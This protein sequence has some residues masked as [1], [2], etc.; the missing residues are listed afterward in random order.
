[1]A[2]AGGRGGGGFYFSCGIDKV[3]ALKWLK[4]ENPSHQHGGG[5][6][7]TAAD[8]QIYIAGHP[9]FV[10]CSTSQKISHPGDSDDLR[11][12]NSM[13][14]FTNLNPI[15]SITSYVLYTICNPCV[16]VQ[17]I[18]IFWKNGVQDMVELDSGQSAQRAKASLNGAEI[19]SDCCT[20]KTE[21]AK[22]Y[23]LNVFKSDQ[24]TWEC[25]NANLSG[26]MTLAVIP[27]NAS[28]SPLSWEIILQYMLRKMNVCVSKQPAIMPGQSYV[29]EDDSCSYKDFRESRNNCFSTPELAAKNLIQ[30]PSNVLHFFNAPLE[31]TEENLVK[32]CD[33]LG[34]KQPTSVKVFSG[35]SQHCSLGLLEL[36]S[37]REALKTLIFLNHYQM[38]NSN[39]PYPYTLK[40]CFC[41]A[42]HAF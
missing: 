8:N 7:L 40:L 23:H 26:K 34:V 33:E 9:A 6:E 24:D 30:H 4:T 2:V 32:I 18:V 15:Y 38:K 19:Y 37:K 39:D 25:I 35:K 16:P 27:T 20:L 28:G 11:I 10:N 42:Q 36:D 29:L 14:L 12:I 31:V 13:L 41:T 1:M 5:S 22:P 21:Y 3:Q 17:R